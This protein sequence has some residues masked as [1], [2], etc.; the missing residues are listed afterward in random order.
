MHDAQCRQT[1]GGFLGQ[2]GRT[3]VAHQGA[4][5]AALHEGLAQGMDQALG[6]LVQIPLQMAHQAGSIIND[7]QDHRR[8]PLPLTG[9]NFART[10]VEVQ[11]PKCIDMVHLKAAHLQTLQ[12]V[13]RGQGTGSG[14]FGLGLAEHALGQEVAAHGL[15][16]RD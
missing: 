7:T 5:Q 1:V 16:G 6:R 13:T 15:V 12:P 4:W 9:E 2:H 11:V 14:A 10:V 3:V 8:H